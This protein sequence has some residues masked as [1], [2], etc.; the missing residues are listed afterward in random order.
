MY[1]WK[2]VAVN[3]GDLLPDSCFILP[4]GS[5]TNRLAAERWYREMC[6]G[7]TS[8]ALNPELFRRE[9]A[10]PPGEKANRNYFAVTCQRYDE[11]S[12]GLEIP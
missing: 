6:T 4:G 11:N 9:Y 12:F 1:K 7:N 3:P 5:E 10:R 8:Y 2:I